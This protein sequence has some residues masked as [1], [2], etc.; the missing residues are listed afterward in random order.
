MCFYG[1]KKNTPECTQPQGHDLLVGPAVA[2]SRLRVVG[3]SALGPFQG[4]G[5]KI[6]KQDNVGNT[7]R[8]IRT[9]VRF[10]CDTVSPLLSIN[11]LRRESMGNWLSDA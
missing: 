1:R 2:P 7:R 8:I 3:E 4:S 10:A 11:Y 9:S 5:G 6:R